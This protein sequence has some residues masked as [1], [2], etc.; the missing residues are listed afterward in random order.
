MISE[1]LFWN[2]AALGVTP[3]TV[4]KTAPK[5]RR[6][7]QHRRNDI[8]LLNNDDCTNTSTLHQTTAATAAAV[9]N[10][11]MEVELENH[12]HNNY[13]HQPFG[14]DDESDDRGDAES[15]TSRTQPEYNFVFEDDNDDD[16]EI[17]KLAGF[18]LSLAG[19]SSRSR[20]LSYSQSSKSSDDHRDELHSHLY[21]S[22]LETIRTSLVECI[23]QVTEE[24]ISRAI[25][26]AF[27]D[28]NIERR[29][30]DSIESDEV[31]NDK[32]QDEV[33]TL[34]K[35]YDFMQGRLNQFGKRKKIM[36]FLQTVL[37]ET[38]LK[39]RR[40][41]ITSPDEVLRTMLSVLSIL[42]IK[43]DTAVILPMDTILLRGLASN[44]S[45]MQLE[46]EFSRYGKV[47]SVAIANHKGSNGFGYCCFLNEESVKK[48]IAN[49]SEIVVNGVKP[50]ITLLHGTITLKESNYAQI[51]G[52]TTNC[53]KSG[54]LL[55]SI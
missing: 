46:H 8:V 31:P 38:F 53:M 52:S 29:N 22:V 20:V 17:D 39:I 9:M 6:K 16:D 14:N 51:D 41:E 48:T 30:R 36:D 28:S 27:A 49:Q 54:R 15:R 40:E 3:L 11:S 12:F 13:P 44:T 47:K 24:M 1:K 26:N 25:I 2:W 45:R 55:W 42:Q 37:D 5:N 4:G 50:N 35:A 34:C 32:Y 18:R 33:N 19:L 43:V 21:S 7:K 23:P 10:E